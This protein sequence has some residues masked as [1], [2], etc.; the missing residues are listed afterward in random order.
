L[1]EL[2]CATVKAGARLPEVRQDGAVTEGGEFAD[3]LSAN[4]AYARTFS[5]PALDGRA[6]RGLAVLTCVDSRIDPLAMLG[7]ESGDAKIIRNAGARVTDD[8]LTTLVVATY[9]LAVE[10]LMVIAHTDCQMLAGSADELHTAIR[11]AGGPE[12]SD[13][14][15]STTADQEASLRADVDRVRSFGRLAALRVGGFV[16]DV[17]TGG[18]T[19]I[20]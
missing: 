3:V 14:S 12:T 8:V 6:A 13:L 18:L 1:V 5:R 4:A 20:C 7:L 11:E 19:R 16:Y 15:F 17:T 2:G 10:R 9:L